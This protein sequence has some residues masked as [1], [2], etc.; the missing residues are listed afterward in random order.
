MRC[1][2][3]KKQLQAGAEKASALGSLIFKKGLSFPGDEELVSLI[4]T[5]VMSYDE[6]SKLSPMLLD[7]V[8]SSLRDDLPDKLKAAPGMDEKAALVLSCAIELGRRFSI[9]RGRRISTPRDILPFVK[10]FTLEH[11]ETFVTFSLTGAQEIINMRVNAIGILDRAII[12]PREIFCDPVSEHA[13]AV[14]CCHNH[15][16]GNCNPSPADIDST[17]VLCRSAEILGLT[18]L[19]HIIF[20]TDSYFSFRENGLITPD[21]KSRRRA[22][23]SVACNDKRMGVYF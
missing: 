22:S 1:Y 7:E 5:S 21:R 14:I 17:K 19:D 12:H 13:S 23:T 15:P 10:Q 6:A 20:T 11:K 18:L 16:Q 3:N 4:L 2:K 9:H 8:K